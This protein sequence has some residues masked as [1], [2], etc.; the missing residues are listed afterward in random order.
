L[1]ARLSPPASSHASTSAFTATLPHPRDHPLKAGGNK[2]ATLI[3]V[4]DQSLL[5]IQRRYA[6]REEEVRE[7]EADPDAMGYRSFSE[8]ASDIEKLVDLI[9]VSGTRKYTAPCV[10]H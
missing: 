8:A 1:Q 9:W 5:K 3:R 2:E 7:K 4:V 6:K 10:V